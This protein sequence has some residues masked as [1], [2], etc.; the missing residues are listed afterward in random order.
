MFLNYLGSDIDW[1]FKTE[2]E[3]KACLGEEGLTWSN[4]IAGYSFRKSCQK[5]ACHRAR[6]CI[7]PRSCGDDIYLPA[8]FTSLAAA[9][10]APEEE[11]HHTPFSE[12]PS[13]VASSEPQ[14]LVSTTASTHTKVRHFARSN[15]LVCCVHFLLWTLYSQ[16][17]VIDHGDT[18]AQS[19]VVILKHIYTSRV[20]ISSD[21]VSTLLR[22]L[23]SISSH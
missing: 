14:L 9:A 18:M 1:G 2:P 12:R 3:E 8:R 20:Q 22:T 13:V 19:S 21:V 4:L 7:V 5:L 23:Q 6:S 17:Q 15:L 10:G 11:R 16:F